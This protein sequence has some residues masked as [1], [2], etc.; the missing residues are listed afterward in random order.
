M[1]QERGQAPLPLGPGAVLQCSGAADIRLPWWLAQPLFCYETSAGAQKEQ[2]PP[3]TPGDRGAVQGMVPWAPSPAHWYLSTVLVGTGCRPEDP[4]EEG[5]W[6]DAHGFPGNRAG[7]P[8]VN[9][10]ATQ[11]RWRKLLGD[12]RVRG[13]GTDMKTLCSPG[14]TNGTN[15]SS[16]DNE[17]DVW[18]M[19]IT[20]HYGIT[21]LK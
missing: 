14:S 9:L 13:M 3:G 1:H 6:R 8:L 15:R 10:C 21:G 17:W 2:D 18:C 19:I 20:L 16:I 11:W 5:T 12:R 4:W 7:S